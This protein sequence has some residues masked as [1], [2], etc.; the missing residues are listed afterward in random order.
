MGETCT[1]AVIGGRARLHADENHK[2]VLRQHTDQ[3][4]APR[5]EHVHSF[6]M[7]QMCLQPNIFAVCAVVKH[8]TWSAKHA[9]DTA[10]TKSTTPNIVNSVPYETKIHTQTTHELSHLSFSLSL[11][12]AHSLSISLVFLL[13]FAFTTHS[14]THTYTNIHTSSTFC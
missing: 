7:P 9:G 11:S 4:E 10:S 6:R 1:L 2:R 5:V 14:H 13:F 8:V 3:S 12:R